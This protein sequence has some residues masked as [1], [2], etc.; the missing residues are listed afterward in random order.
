M[1]VFIAYTEID[2]EFADYLAQR[3]KQSGVPVW[4]DLHDAPQDAIEAWRTASQ[5]AFVESSIFL[6]IL[7]PEA[8]RDA[9]L[10]R[11]WQ[12]SLEQRRTVIAAIAEPC[13]TSMP[14]RYYADFSR[15]FEHAFHRLMHL[16][17]EQRQRSGFLRRG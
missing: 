1:T 11:Q 14:L 13:V 17:I 10:I 8:L 3:L 7:S 16:L 15:N 4:I 5:E 6:V 12:D 2:N 9:H